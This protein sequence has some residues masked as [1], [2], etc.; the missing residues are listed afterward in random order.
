MVLKG[1]LRIDLE[2]FLFDEIEVWNDKSS[3]FPDHIEV[4]NLVQHLVE[5]ATREGIVTR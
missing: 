1:M 5:A 2:K 4:E 3:V